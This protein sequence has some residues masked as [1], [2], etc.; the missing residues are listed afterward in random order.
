[1]TFQSSICSIRP[2]NYQVFS[3]LDVDK[4]SIAVTF[5]DHNRLINSLRLPY[6][7]EQLL[8]YVRKHFPQ[9]QVAFVYELDL[10][11]LVSTMT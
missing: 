1:M 4:G 5:S 2:Q 10:P 6:S 3:G 7:S 9:Q 8:N 11:A